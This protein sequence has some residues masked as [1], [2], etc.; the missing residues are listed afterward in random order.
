MQII[1]D[2]Y[3]HTL[4]S[5][6]FIERIGICLGYQFMNGNVADTDRPTKNKKSTASVAGICLCQAEFRL[7]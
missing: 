2:Y 5:I 3:T 7:S 4:R 6:M 1:S